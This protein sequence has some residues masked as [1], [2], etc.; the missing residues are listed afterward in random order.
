MVTSNGCIEVFD[1]AGKTYSAGEI[2]MDHFNADT[3]AEYQKMNL[4]YPF[5]SRKDWEIAAFLESSNLSMAA[6][7]KF[8]SLEL[9]D[10]ISLQVLRL[11]TVSMSPDILTSAF[12]LHL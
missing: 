10:V 8:L 12:I 3:Y 6:I 9:V 5:A 1:G 7:D 4:Y 2:F 11:L